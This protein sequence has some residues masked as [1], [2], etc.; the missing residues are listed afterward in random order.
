MQ[1]LKLS[2]NSYLLLFAY[3]YNRGFFKKE[4]FLKKGFLK[5]SSAYF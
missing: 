1:G 5:P 3:Y 2:G 4:G